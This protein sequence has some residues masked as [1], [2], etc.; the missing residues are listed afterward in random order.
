MCLFDKLKKSDTASLKRHRIFLWVYLIEAFKAVEFFA[1]I[2]IA[3]AGDLDSVP[4][5]MDKIIVANI[6]AH[7]G[8]SRFV[9]IGKEYQIAH[10]RIADII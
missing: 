8:N 4:A 9:C 7:V 5:G 3:Q 1:P 6:N 10:L 2:G